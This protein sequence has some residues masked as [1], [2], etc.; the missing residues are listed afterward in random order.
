M[1]KYAKLVLSIG[2]GAFAGYLYYYF[3][4]CNSGGCAIT[5]SWTSS[6]LFGAAMGAVFGFPDRK[7]NSE[8]KDGNKASD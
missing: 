5:S 8:E 2:V 6:T 1:N 3:I 4:G 7:K